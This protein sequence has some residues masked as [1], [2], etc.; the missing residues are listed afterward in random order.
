[1]TNVKCQVQLIEDLL[2]NNENNIFKIRICLCKDNKSFF[3]KSITV[4]FSFKKVNVKK[5]KIFK[6]K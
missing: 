6:K 4:K 3:S 1:M 2:Y 5:R